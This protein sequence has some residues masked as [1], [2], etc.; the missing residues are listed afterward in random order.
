MPL[1][2]GLV[3]FPLY[4]SGYAFCHICYETSNLRP[5]NCRGNYRIRTNSHAIGGVLSSCSIDLVDGF[6][7][8]VGNRN[9]AA[10]AS[11]TNGP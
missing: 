10:R 5:L 1:A 6:S 9:G 2:T 11:N 7:I 4:H 8:I 3:T